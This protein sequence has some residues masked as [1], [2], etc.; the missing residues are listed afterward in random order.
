MK[1][2]M[3]M[4]P[5]I[6]VPPNGYGGIERIVEIF[7]IEYTKMGHEVHLLVTTGSYVEG[8]TVYPFGKEGFPPKKADALKALPT[9]WRF[10][11]KYRNDFDLVHNFGRLAYLIPL[12]NHPVKKIMSYQREIRNR[13]I[14][15]INKLRN[16]N[17]FFT[18]CS[19]DLLSRIEG[20]GTWA[21]IYNAI[22]FSKYNLQQTVE[23]DAPLMFLGRLE[24]VKGCHTAIEVAKKTGH[25]LI[26]AG[27]ISTLPEEI[28][29][30]E[31]EIKP[32]IDDQQIIYVGALNDEQKDY[33]LGISRALIFPVEWNEPFGIV[34]IEAMACGTPVIGFNRGSVNEV[35]DEGITGYKVN[36]RDEMVEAVKRISY[37]DRQK[38]GEHAK[39]RF[40]ASVVALEYLG[41]VKSPKKSVVIV[42]TG[43]PAAN[44]RV[45][46]EYEALKKEG[47]EVKVLCTYSAEWSYKIDEQKFNSGEL[48]K[49]DFVL[50]GGNPYNKKTAYFFSR[51]LFKVCNKVVRFF[52]FFFLKEIT[53]VRSSLFLWLYVKKY[54]ADIYI[55]HYLGA[56][57]AAI[58]ASKKYKSAVIFDAEDFH[59]GEDPYYPEQ[60]R[61]VIEI[62]DRLLPKVNLITT[63]S[64]LISNSYQQLYP[65]KKVIT[66]NNV[67]SIKYL[68][69]VKNREE[70]NLKLFWFSQ[71]IGP[72]RGL[73]MI[74]EALNFI[75]EDITLTLLGNIRNKEYIQ[76][77]LKRSTRPGKIKFID[78]VAPELVFK[79]AAGFDIGLAAEIPHC[80]NR[81]ICLTNKIFTYLLAG[82]CILASDTSAQNKFMM[83]N[84]KVGFLYKHNDPAELAKQIKQIFYNREQLTACKM[85]ASSLAQSTLNWEKESEK[86]ILEVNNLLK[87]V[88]LK[89]H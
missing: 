21:A 17:M 39:K 24:R 34:M 40:D 28:D 70:Q 62:E 30:F 72:N 38:C 85:N 12:L 83:S 35:I 22:I 25:K 54:K 15:L 13:N 81:D 56:L 18:A 59:R 69:P 78:P 61:D 80:I 19:A 79:I 86:F 74:V 14:W 82:N 58:R 37:I 50:L 76:N 57:P 47:F 52:P 51:L 87:D 44:P 53:F 88:N 1:I 65:E 26:I 73:E 84:P 6:L 41:L 23:A 67:F 2:L 27:N 33:W 3:V 48:S 49:N 7:A 20:Q 46:K 32:H 16:K 9:A 71:N 68:Q 5:G 11:W 4:D 77:L 43:Q 42:T 66:I 45:V 75:E 64:P 89:K 60:I 63:A 31:K 10:L 36:N 29:Y 55:A 8:C